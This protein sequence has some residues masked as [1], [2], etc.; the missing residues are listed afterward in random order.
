MSM[1]GCTVL[2]AI[3]FLKGLSEVQVFLDLRWELGPDK[4]IIS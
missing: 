1:V 2:G 3:L 4:Y